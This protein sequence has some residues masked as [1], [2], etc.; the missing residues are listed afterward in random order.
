[1]ASGASSYGASQFGA[2]LRYR[3]APTNLHRPTAY[4]RTTS[5]LTG[6]REAEVAA[7]LALRPLARLPISTAAELRA[8]RAGQR[9]IVRPAIYAVTELA[10]FEL[11]LAFS[12]EAYAQAGYV[13]GEYATAFIDGQLRVDRK[14]AHVGPATVRAGGGAWGGAQKGASRLDVGPA[15]TLGMK[16]GPVPSRLSLDWRFRVAGEA[17]PADGPALTLSAGF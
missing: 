13:G 12:G 17:E 16:I 3:L 5:A 15:A 4:L 11:P 9:V 8:L 7:G 1:M 14:L 10:P 6:A 2:V